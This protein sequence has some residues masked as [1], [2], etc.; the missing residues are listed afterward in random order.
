MKLID[1]DALYNIIEKMNPVDYGSIFSYEA[2]N[3]VGD[4][5]RDILRIIDGEPPRD[6]IRH[7]EWAY[8]TDDFTPHSRCSICGYNKP[9]IAGE[10]INQEP[11]NFCN[12][13]GSIMS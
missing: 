11:R 13:C 10:N 9:I 3:A 2:H 7:G 5:L 8:N 6:L 4:V 1:A 12:N